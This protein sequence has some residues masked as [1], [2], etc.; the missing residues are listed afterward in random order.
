M[1]FVTLLRI[2]WRYRIAVAIGWIVAVL[3]GLAFLRGP[4]SHF[5]VASMRVVL[6]TPDSQTVDV[7]PDGASTLDWRADLAA[8]LVGTDRARQRIA[9]QMGI[10]VDD[11]AVVAPF[12]SVPIVAT[13]LPK[14]ALETAA[15]VPQPYQLAIQAAL[16]LPIILIDA[17]APSAQRAAQLASTAADALKAE[18]AVESTPETQKFVVEDVGPAR[19][20]EI[21]NSPRRMMAAAVV[22]IAF[23]MWCT[24]ITLFAGLSRARRRTR[25]RMRPGSAE[26]VA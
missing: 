19:S 26:Q 9:Q 5:G 23:V 8:D 7:D 20:R 4:T 10:A 12:M 14:T 15:T 2:L 17:R 25:A 13:P 11:L 16:P 3:L 21:V 18:F 24:S 22:F 6:D 1:E